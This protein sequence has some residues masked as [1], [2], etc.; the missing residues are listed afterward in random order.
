M[1]TIKNVFALLKKKPGFP[2][3]KVLVLEGGG[4]RGIFLVKF[5]LNRYKTYDRITDDLEN[6]HKG[7]E[8]IYP[9]PDF[10]VQRLTRDEKKI[11]EG[12]EQGVFAA[13]SFLKGTS[14]LSSIF[15]M[16]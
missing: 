2:R 4:M 5:L 6:T 1:K 15:L 12:F 16:A 13:V 14:Y 7:I 8:V 10:E 3:K 9:P 11:L